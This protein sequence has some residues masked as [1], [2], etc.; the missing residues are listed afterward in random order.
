MEVARISKEFEERVLIHDPLVKLRL[1][2][3][4]FQHLLLHA[5]FLVQGVGCDLVDLFEFIVIFVDLPLELLIKNIVFQVSGQDLVVG[6]ELTSAQEFFEC[7][8]RLK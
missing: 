1:S 8:S 5:G 4:S 6:Y 3:C 7:S 2:I